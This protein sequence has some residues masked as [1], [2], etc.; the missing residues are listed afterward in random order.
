MQKIFYILLLVCSLATSCVSESN[1]RSTAEERTLQNVETVR[2]DLNGD[3]KEDSIIMQIP[4]YWLD[5]GDFTR[6]VFDIAGQRKHAFD[7]PEGWVSYDKY[8]TNK[9]AAASVPGTVDS[10]SR[11]LSL[12]KINDKEYRVLLFG[13]PASHAPGKLYVFSVINGSVKIDYFKPLEITKVTDLN[14]D[15][16][17]EVVGNACFTRQFEDNPNFFSYTPYLVYSTRNGFFY[18][19]KLT[20]QYN[21]EF[22]FGYF[23]PRCTQDTVVVKTQD[24]TLIMELSRAKKIYVEE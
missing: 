11:M 4:R 21:K 12:I 6:I 3:G 23:G 22:Y 9:A 7:N 1:R 14:G 8:Q 2:A 20:E 10:K 19:E 16:Y 13:Q 18:D 5:S 15:R 17:P 24:S